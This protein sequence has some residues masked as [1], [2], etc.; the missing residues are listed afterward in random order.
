MRKFIVGI[1]L[2]LALTGCMRALLV[3]E[4]RDG[5]IVFYREPL[6]DRQ[7]SDLT[8]QEYCQRYQKPVTWISTVMKKGGGYHDTYKCG[9]V[10]PAKMT[11]GE[12]RYQSPEPRS[13]YPRE[14]VERERPISGDYFGSRRQTTD[15][16]W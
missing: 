14:E 15:G 16:D 6:Q 12:D 10:P 5:L 2:C 3:A 13:D 4:N 1:C 7:V 11:V 8:A 9:L